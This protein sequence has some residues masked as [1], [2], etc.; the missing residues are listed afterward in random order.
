M[1]M[2]GLM[3]TGLARQQH[4]DVLVQA[5]WTQVL[6]SVVVSVAKIETWEAPVLVW[7]VGFDVEVVEPVEKVK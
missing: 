7:L 1:Q 5:F 6:S 2:T 3:K 4:V